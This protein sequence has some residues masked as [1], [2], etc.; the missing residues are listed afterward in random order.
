MRPIASQIVAARGLLGWSTKDLALAAGISL[1]AVQKLESTP[2][3][4]E[5]TRSFGAVAQ[6]LIGRGIIF[7]KDLSRVGVALD[8]RKRQ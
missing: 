6:A 3:D 8:T 2:G 1:Y 7:T 5:P 4:L